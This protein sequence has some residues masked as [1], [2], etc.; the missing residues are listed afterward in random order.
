VPDRPDASRAAAAPP[1]A[2]RTEARLGELAEIVAT[3]CQVMAATGLVEHVLGHISL[4]I[5]PEELL[6]RCRGADEAGLAYTT[7]DDVRAVTLDG[8]G[9]L[10]AWR[11]P[12]E[13]PIHTEIMRR[14]PEVTAVVH[15]HPPS[16]VAATLLDAPLVPVYGAYD[17]PGARLAAGGLPTWGRSAL[18]TSATLAG[19]MADALGDGPVV[20]L[21]GHGLVSVA[22]GP[23]ETA[24]ARAVI[25]ALAVDRLARTS[26]AVR[27]AGGTPAP[28]SAEDLAALPDLGD[29][30]AVDTMWRH[31]QRRMLDELYPGWRP[32]TVPCG[33]ALGGRPA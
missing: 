33:S 32:P 29:S 28:I 2:D 15:A 24:P 26:L 10:G 30:F 27:A 3:A 4:R 18:I 21:R 22:G 6:V 14:R 5:A 1:V 17:I 31:L 8:S 19:E 20:L 23:P 9:D 16:T 13:L 11:A 25:Q 7:A 12:H